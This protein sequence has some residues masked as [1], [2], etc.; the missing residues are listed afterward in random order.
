VHDGAIQ[1]LALVARRG[2]EIG[3]ATAELAELA[4][5]QE[6]ALRRLVSGDGELQTGEVIDL[7]PVLRGRE[8]DKVSTSLPATPVLLDA[9][10]AAE[11]D[12]AVGNALDNVAAHAGPG[13][14]AY[15]LLEDVD[16]A[17]VVSVRDDGPGIAEGRLDEALADGH[18]GIAKSIVGR[19][20]WLGGSA[21]LRTGPDIGTEWELTIP[22]GSARGT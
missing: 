6:R 10:V 17:V 3:G 1:V 12:A 22:R 8:S 19:M 9:A 16:D 20:E 7:V 2:R 11:V 5:A 15:I 13:A 14:H 21:K 4:G 18:V